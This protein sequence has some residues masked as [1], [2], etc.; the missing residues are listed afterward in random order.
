MEDRIKGYEAGADAYLSKPFDPAELLSVVNSVLQRDEFPASD[1]KS[2]SDGS[3]TESGDNR[4]TAEDLKRELLEI[5]SLLRDLGPN[6]KKKKNRISLNF[7]PPRESTKHKQDSSEGQITVES[8]HRELRG[9][10]ESI[11]SSISQKKSV[12]QDVTNI[13]VEGMYCVYVCVIFDH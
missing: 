13:I 6:K 12:A 10:K 7:K 5:K 2:D 4:V 11:E 3:M 8:L 9:V 1:V